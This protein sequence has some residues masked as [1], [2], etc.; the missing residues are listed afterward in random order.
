MRRLIHR[1]VVGFEMV[2][3][4]CVLLLA[5]PFI[6]MKFGVDAIR[7]RIGDKWPD[8]DRAKAVSF[9]IGCLWPLVVAVVWL[10]IC[11]LAVQHVRSLKNTDI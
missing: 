5:S 8:S 11:W 10:V 2:V 7:G 3:F 6:L 4:A 9:W 1:I